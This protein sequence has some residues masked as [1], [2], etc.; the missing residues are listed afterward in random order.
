MR[1]AFY[2][3]GFANK[4]FF[5]PDGTFRLEGSG[6]GL[7][8]ALSRRLVKGVIFCRRD[9]RASS[10]QV[11]FYAS[12]YAPSKAFAFKGRRKEKSAMTAAGLIGGIGIEWVSVLILVVGIIGL[13]L[14]GLAPGIRDR[15]SIALA[16]GL[17]STSDP[18]RHADRRDPHLYSLANDY[19]LVAVPMFVLMASPYWITPG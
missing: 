8:S 16:L 14:I 17:F 5:A 2:L 13:M 18:R 15:R 7:Q 10:V 4:A 1:W 3:V 11:I 19:V 12:R 6:Y 9:D